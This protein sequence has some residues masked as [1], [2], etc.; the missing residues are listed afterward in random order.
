MTPALSRTLNAL[1]LI[2][3]CVVLIVAFVEQLA[4]GE[5]PCPLC[6]LQRVGFVG[7][8]VALALNVRFGPRPSHYG[9]MILAAAVGCAVSVRQMMLHISPGDP[10]FDPPLLGLHFYTWAT[11]VFVAI[12]L[13]AAAML[14]FDRQFSFDLSPIAWTGLALGAV[15]L[16]LAMALGNGVSTILECGGGLCPD[17]PTSYLLLQDGGLRTL[18]GK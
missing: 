2:G 13:G 11:F 9:M 15:I 3:I 8:A 7:V 12:V 1:G 14:L 10:G 6:L 18:L 17:N 5:L 4:F 16:G